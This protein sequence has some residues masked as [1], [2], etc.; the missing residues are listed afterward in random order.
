MNKLIVQRPG[1]RLIVPLFAGALIYSV[2]LMMLNNLAALNDSFFTI[3]LYSCIM[4]TFLVFEANLHLYDR[5]LPP[6]SLSFSSMIISLFLGILISVLTAWAGLWIYF[7]L[8]MGY[9]FVLAFITEFRLFAFLFGSTGALYGLFYISHY[10]L[11]RKNNDL[12]EREETLTQVLEE[13]LNIYQSEMNPSLLFDSLE[14]ALT[15]LE[16]N[17]DDAEYLLDELAMVYRYILTTKD[18]KSVPLARE[19]EVCEHFLYLINSRYRKFI[20]LDSDRAPKETEVVPGAILNTLERIIYETIITEVR[21]LII[22]MEADDDYLI[23]SHKENQRLRHN[24]TTGIPEQFE[25]A[26]SILTERPVMKIKAFGECFYKL[27]LLNVQKVVT[28]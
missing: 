6:G 28:G 7:K 18:D 17:P 24:H 2:L 3:E 21:P 27:P 13:E 1:F 15:L 12:F 16:T 26:Y 14:S 9:R 19:L 5:L 22:Q 8:V 25:N 10:L 11:M 20:R 4:I 23:I